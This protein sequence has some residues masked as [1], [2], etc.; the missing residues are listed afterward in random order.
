MTAK[1]LKLTEQKRQAAFVE[2]APKPRTI[3]PRLIGFLSAISI[4]A[5]CFSFPL[6]HL[7]QLAAGNDLYSH[8][9]LIP[10]ICLYLVWMRRENLPR[11]FAPA[12]KQA[13]F[14]VAAGFLVI[15]A[16]WIAP[17]NNFVKREN[18]LAINILAFL[19]FFTGICCFFLGK[20]FMRAIA[21]PMAL[22]IFAIPFPDFLLR[23]IETFL[24]HGSVIFAEFFFQLSGIPTVCDGL[25]FTLPDCSLQV[26]PECSGIHST[27]VLVITS[28][29]GGWLFLRSPW[30]RAALVLA[31]IPL[32]LIRNGF[33]IF[34]LGRLC[35]AYGPQMLDSPIHHHGG[36]LFFALSLIPFLLLLAFLRKTER[37]DHHFKPRKSL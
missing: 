30:R 1:E 29:L 6:C 33:R 5:L 3:P 37:L 34:V 15:A 31:V 11:L 14:F 17:H 32:A 9:P 19:L 26:A 27:L 2:P 12:S 10:F 16:Y 23:W 28:L 25:I 8:I 36:P 13:V 4:L 22:L 24:Q 7:L 21:F 20:I 35:V 18:Y